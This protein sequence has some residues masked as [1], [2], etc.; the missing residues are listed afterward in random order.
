MFIRSVCAVVHSVTLSTDV[1]TAAVISATE[2]VRPTFNRRR[3][4]VVCNTG[5]V[6]VD[7]AIL[8]KPTIQ[9]E[10]RQQ[11]LTAFDHAYVTF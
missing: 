10:T 6:N 8:K 4:N 11:N 3:Y 1:N 7:K 2:L 9:T 5:A